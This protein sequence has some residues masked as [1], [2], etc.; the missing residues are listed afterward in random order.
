VVKNC[1]ETRRK[2][3]LAFIFLLIA[4]LKEGKLNFRGIVKEFEIE[5]EKKTAGILLKDSLKP[6][7][8]QFPAQ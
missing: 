6:T 4:K 3:S 7:F 5:Q 2:C 8:F 1:G